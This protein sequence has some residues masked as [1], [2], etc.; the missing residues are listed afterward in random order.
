MQQLRAKDHVRTSGRQRLPTSPLP[1]PAF[2]PHTRR[3]SLQWLR[4]RPWQR[5]Q[6]RCRGYTVL[7]RQKLGLEAHQTS[8]LAIS[9]IASWSPPQPSA[10]S[11]AEQRGGGSEGRIVGGGVCAEV[12]EQFFASAWGRHMRWVRENRS[13]LPSI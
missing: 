5:R 6:A 7:P 3:P 8:S 11:W 2:I 9:G 1:L 4:R 10:S 12:C 13:L